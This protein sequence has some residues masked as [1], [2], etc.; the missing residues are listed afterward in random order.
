VRGPFD[1]RGSKKPDRN[2]GRFPSIEPPASVRRDFSH[3]DKPPEPSVRLAPSAVLVQTVVSRD[4][5][6]Y[7]VDHR[8][9]YLL[10]LIDGQTTV[11]GLLDL[12]AMSAE[13]TLTLLKDLLKQG[14]VAVR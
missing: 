12:S 4:L 10:S 7:A 2:L 3:L 6:R 13:E 1:R 5:R 9:G 8:A 11:E 14:L